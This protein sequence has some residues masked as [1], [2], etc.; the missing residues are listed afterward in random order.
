ME[1]HLI[2]DGSFEGLLCCVFSA[3]E[4]KLKVASISEE[5]KKQPALFGNRH[6]IITDST[7]AFRVWRALAKKSNFQCQQKLY[8]SYLSELPNI[9]LSIFKMISQIFSSNISIESD[10]SNPVV[11]QITDTAKK[12]GREK[13]RMEAFVRFQK[14]KDGTY[15][16]IIEP[17]FNVLPLITSHFKE[18]YADQKWIIYDRARKFGFYYDLKK[19]DFIYLEWNAEISVSEDEEAFQCLWKNYFHSTNIKKRVN[20]KLHIRHIP[21]KYWKYLTEKTPFV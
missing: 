15:F 19:V 2:Y 20:K 16:S 14:G 6:L 5:N 4:E 7:K 1:D 21:R 12:V 13:H 3:F 18:R 17:E 8:W 9:D 10:Y 11:L